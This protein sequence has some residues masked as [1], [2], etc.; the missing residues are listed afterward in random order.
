MKKT[1]EHQ[2]NF[3]LKR[4]KQASF[5][6]MSSQV[7]EEDPK[8][9]LFVLS[10]YKFVAKMLE[11]KEKV[12]EIGCADGLGT[13]IVAQAVKELTATDFEPIF[14]KNAKKINKGTKI[15]FQVSNILEKKQKSDYDGAYCIDV[16]EHIAPSLEDKFLTKIC[17]QLTK[18]GC[19]IIGTP[20]KES[21]IYASKASLEGH[22]NCK[23]GSDLKNLCRKYFENVF[24]FSMN[25]EIIHTGFTKMAHYL[26][27]ICSNKR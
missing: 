15:N 6:L 7:W 19:L 12:L 22:V 21:Q 11:G 18:S 16:F 13:R 14:I 4:K 2:Y 3:L 1:K 24:L 26:F 20:S 27:A 17:S 10:R 5:G 25:D 23:S 8:R 9:I